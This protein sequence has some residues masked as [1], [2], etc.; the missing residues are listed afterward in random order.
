MNNKR[1]EIKRLHVIVPMDLFLRLRQVNL[2]HDVD[3]LVTTNLY[4]KVEEEEKRRGELKDENKQGQ[5]YK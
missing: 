1:I 5:S 2:L 3:E 4:D